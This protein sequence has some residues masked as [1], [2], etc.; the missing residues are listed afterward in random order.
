MYQ[1][2]Y[3]LIINVIGGMKVLTHMKIYQYF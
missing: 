3:F 1:K 2:K